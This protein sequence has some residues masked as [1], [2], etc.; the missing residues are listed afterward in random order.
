[1]EVPIQFGEPRRVNLTEDH[2]SSPLTEPRKECVSESIMLSTLPPLLIQLIL[3]ASYPLH[4]PP[5]LLSIRATHLWLPRIPLLHNALA[6]MWN[7]GEGVLYQWVEFLR[8][9]DFLQNL[10]LISSV[11]HMSIKCVSFGFIL[12]AGLIICAEFRIHL[13]RSSFH[14]WL[15][16]THP[17]NRPIFLRILIHAPSVLRP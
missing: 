10:D 3:P 12:G 2:P 1:M 14:C 7:P 16:T 11:E 4:R 9:G 6:S 8:T 13:P 5:Q 17:Q 15:R